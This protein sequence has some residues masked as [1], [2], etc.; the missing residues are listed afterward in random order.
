MKSA[1]SV[2][3][4]V[5]AVFVGVPRGGCAQGEQALSPVRQANLATVKMSYETNLAKYANNPDMMV[6]SG[7]LANRREKWVRIAA[8]ATGV[9]SGDPMEFWLISQESGHD[10]EAVAVSFAQPSDVHEALVFIG[11][12]PGW[13]VSYN[14][15]RFWPKASGRS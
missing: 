6:K 9:P 7:L 11:L 10:Y 8:E 15:F 13:P 5:I 1:S 14:R 2:A 4:L 12:T 3:L